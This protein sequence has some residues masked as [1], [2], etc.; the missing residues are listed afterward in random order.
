[1]FSAVEVGVDS[2]ELP[3]FRYQSKRW[4]SENMQKIY[5]ILF[6]RSA[7]PMQRSLEWMNAMLDVYGAPV[8]FLERCQETMR[9]STDPKWVTMDQS[10]A[11]LH[12]GTNKDHCLE[13]MTW[14]ASVSVQACKKEKSNINSKC[15]FFFTKFAYY[16]PCAHLLR[17]FVCLFVRVEYLNTFC[18]FSSRNW[19]NS[20][21]N[22][23]EILGY[24]CRPFFL[25]YVYFLLSLSLSVRRN[26]GFWMI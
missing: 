8:Q 26:E 19:G 16:T 21:D 14:P 20:T 24:P 22:A 2:Y 6:R 7:L 11:T 15:C 9:R 25:F 17:L 12:T 13:R 3:L 5:P 18:S 4:H 10:F 1:M 23:T